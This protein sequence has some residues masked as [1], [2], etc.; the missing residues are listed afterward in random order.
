[1]HFEITKE[2]KNEIEISGPVPGR[3]GSLLT[4]ERIGEKTNA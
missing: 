1:M 2:E 4:L 3:A